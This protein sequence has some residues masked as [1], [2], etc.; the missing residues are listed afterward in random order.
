MTEVLDKQTEMPIS[1]GE[2]DMRQFLREL[3]EYPRL[4]PEE[5]RE[6]ARRCAEGD[7]E[8][9]RKMVG[10][11]LRLV[12]SIARDY[13]GR[14]VPL[15]DLI[16]DNGI[17]WIINTSENGA[18]AMTDEVLMRSRALAAGIP[19][20]T[21]MA[22]M[23]AALEG[24]TDKLEFGRFEVCSLQEYHRHLAPAGRRI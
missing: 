1:T 4:T 19:I 9:V 14:G 16:Q 23:T 22:G 17:Q 5:E 8:A 7:E 18:E 13:A 20:T 6:L 10:S 21:T 12:V 15:L 3:K 24:L 11:N 2:E